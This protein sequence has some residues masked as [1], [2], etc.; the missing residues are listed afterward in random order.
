MHKYLSL[1]LEIIF[2]NVP[3]RRNP[4]SMKF[5]D[6]FDIVQLQCPNLNLFRPITQPT[7]FSAFSTMQQMNVI[8]EYFILASCYMVSQLAWS[9]CHIFL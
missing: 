4:K 8:N 1:T 7:K 3:E 2:T 6:S 9:E 5:R